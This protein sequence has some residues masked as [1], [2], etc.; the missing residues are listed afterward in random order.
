MAYVEFG[1]FVTNEK[2][3][4]IRFNNSSFEA[5]WEDVKKYVPSASAILIR[6][7]KPL[8]PLLVNQAI[9]DDQLKNA[10]EGMGLEI[11]ISSGAH[12]PLSFL[13]MLHAARLTPL[14]VMGGLPSGCERELAPSS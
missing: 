2:P 5:L 12:L 8:L 13:A 4:A 7:R 9:W 1:V 6:R 10:P 14:P 3:L 11:R